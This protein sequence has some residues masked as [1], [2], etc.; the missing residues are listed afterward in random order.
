MFAAKVPFWTQ[1]AAGGGFG[2]SVYFANTGGQFLSKSSVSQLVTWKTTSGFTIECWIYMNSFPASINPGFGNQDGGGT[3]YWSFGPITSGA[4]EF[5]HWAPGTNYFTTNTGVLTANTWHAVSA[6]FTTSGSNTTASMYIDGTRVNIRLNNAG[7]FASTASTTGG[8]VSTGTV[9]GAGIYGAG[10]LN[11]YID[12]IRVS[13]VARYSGSSYTVATTG[14]TL[15]SSTYLLIPPTGANG[16]TSIPFESTGGNG[17]MTNAR[18]FVTIS[19]SLA[20]HT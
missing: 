14:F 20:N 11:G 10:K 1:A 16:T 15:D 7:A 13:N 17:T 5:Y 12:N 8:V 4:L 19:N 9:F 3:N 2:N 6:V 18:N